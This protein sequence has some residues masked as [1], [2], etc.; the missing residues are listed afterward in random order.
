MVVFKL[1]LNWE[2]PVG[3]FVKMNRKGVDACHIVFKNFA[4][5][6]QNCAIEH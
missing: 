6:R 5:I 1:T 3:I 4:K 2:R